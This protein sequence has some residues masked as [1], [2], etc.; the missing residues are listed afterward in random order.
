MKNY[1]LKFKIFYF[2]AVVFIFSLLVFGL[3]NEVNAASSSLYLSPPSGTYEVGS[4]F[5]VKV[6]VDSGGESIN[7]AEGTLIFNP[8]EL[9]ITKIS[10]SNSIFSLWTTNPTFSNSTGNIVFGGGTSSN[11]TGTSGTVVTITFKAKASASAQVSF[12]SGWILAADG[13]GTNILGNMNG[14]VYTL[15]SKII[16]PPA[17]EVPSE[18]EYT[19]P[20]T[21]SRIPTV[22]VISSDSHPDPN[23]WYSNNDPEFSWKIPSDVTAIKLLIGH[24]PTAAPT[25]LYSPPI[26]E[27][28]LKDLGDGVWY[29]HIRFKNQYGWGKI[30]H[31]KILIDTQPPEPFEI[32]V[33]NGEDPTNPSP[34]LDFR[35]TDSLSGVEYYE[36]KI[37]EKESID[38]D[39]KAMI[40][41]PYKMLSQPPGKYT[42]IVKAVDK[43]GNSTIAT[44]EIMI[45]QI[46]KPVISDFPQ[47]IKLGET[48]TIK[49]TSF[50]P[51]ATII[52]FI[53]KEGEE[54]E[55]KEA[56]TDSEGNWLLVYDKGLERGTYRIWAQATDERGAKS[57]PTEKFN[58]IVSSPD[59]LKFGTTAISYLIIIAT[60][61]VLIVV[62]VG[63]IFYTWYRISLWRKRLSKETKEVSRT[64]TKAFR[65]LREEVQEQI[66]HL[67]KKPGLTKGEKKIRDKLQEALDI[68]EKFIE[69]EIKDIKKEL[70]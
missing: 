54:V 48:L 60:L 30:L 58:L 53:K 1:N 36:V 24:L 65:A 63:V 56:E 5:S 22:P 4:I 19:P 29:F 40:V 68:S 23:Q 14:G 7:A 35:A 32:K 38:I 41:N 66:E 69:R 27:K 47:T 31:R 62:A 10:T 16:T 25:V 33:D 57:E 64:T 45:E 51:E 8:V 43:A 26:F 50:Y 18:T 46:E 49:G 39:V 70:E 3:V 15:K 42:I 28:K 44:T 52:V 55:A 20:T 17:E 21:P 12:S 11:F 67:D 37:E 34:T 13:K 61:I 59:L 2:L 9:N 6:K